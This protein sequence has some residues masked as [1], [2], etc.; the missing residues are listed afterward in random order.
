MKVLIVNWLDTSS[1]PAR[2]V[3]VFGS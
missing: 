2:G 1:F 3:F